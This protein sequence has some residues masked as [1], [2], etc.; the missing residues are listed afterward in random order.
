MPNVQVKAKINIV[1]LSEREFV[2][3]KEATPSPPPPPPPTP[4]NK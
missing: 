1:K 2:I 3:H 4:K